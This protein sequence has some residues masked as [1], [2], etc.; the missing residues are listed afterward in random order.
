VV[1]V[2]ILLLIFWPLS[3]L[4]PPI[5]DAGWLLVSAGK[6]ESLL[7]TPDNPLLS[8][9]VSNLLKLLK[10]SSSSPPF[11]QAGRSKSY[12]L[13]AKDALLSALESESLF[14]LSVKDENPC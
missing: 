3:L 8:F 13:F 9:L 6:S 4:L 2:S 7:F 11:N 12:L 1:T 14:F 10:K 5:A